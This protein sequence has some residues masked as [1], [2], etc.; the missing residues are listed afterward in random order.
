MSMQTIIVVF[1]VLVLVVVVGMVSYTVGLNQSTENVKQARR[2]VDKAMTSC[3]QFSND[4]TKE[5]LK[6]HK[7]EMKLIA[8]GHGEQPVAP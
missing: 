1:V 8:L 4:L 5:K 3:L 2:D 6:A 7:L